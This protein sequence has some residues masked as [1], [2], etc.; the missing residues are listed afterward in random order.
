MV[1]CRSLGWGVFALLAGL[2]VDHMSQGEVDKNYTAVFWMA[3]LIMGFD[4]FASTKLRVSH[5]ANSIS[6]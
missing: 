6:F 2:L 1:L 3:L 5:R 4:V